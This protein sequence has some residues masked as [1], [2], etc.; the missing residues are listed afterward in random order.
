MDFTRTGGLAGVQEQLHIDVDG[1][2]NSSARTSFR[3]DADRLTDLRNALSDPALLGP[4]PRS[5]SGAVCSDGYLYSVRTPTWARTTDD[6]AGPHPAFDRVLQLLM[7]WV[8]PNP[9]GPSDSGSPSAGRRSHADL[10]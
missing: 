6:C 7:A 10:K 5:T 2:V 9:A 3:L 1:T 4:A 8:H